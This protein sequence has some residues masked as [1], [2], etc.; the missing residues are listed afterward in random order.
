MRIHFG[1]HE[2]APIPVPMQTVLKQVISAGLK[3]H[4]EYAKINCEINL[5]FVTQEEIRR[6]NSCYRSKDTPTDVLS[7][8]NQGAKPLATGRRSKPTL[9]LGDIVICLEIA[10]S[11]A[12]EYGHSLERELAFLTAHGLLHLLGYDHNTPQE[13]SR[14][15]DAQKEILAR[16]GV[17]REHSGSAAVFPTG[18]S[19]IAEQFLSI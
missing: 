19:E 10:E 12:R 1:E 16:V 6:L 13:E 4:P 15:I 11:Q 2:T 7:F 14:M 3:K 5:T 17:C 18:R 9:H 8:P